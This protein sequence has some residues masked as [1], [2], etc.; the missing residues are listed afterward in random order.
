M[1]ENDC[2]LVGAAFDLSK[3]TFDRVAIAVC[4]VT[5][6]ESD[7]VEETLKP[8]STIDEER[9]LAN[10]MILPEM[11]VEVFNEYHRSGG[12][13]L[14]ERESGSMATNSQWHWSSIS[15]TVSLMAT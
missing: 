6:L 12:K 3:D 15:M 8:R 10:G 14:D 2:I 13:E 1:S 11:I 5:K 9:P 4:F 7:S